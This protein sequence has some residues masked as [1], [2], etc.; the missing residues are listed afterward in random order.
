MADLKSVVLENLEPPM[1]EK[2]TLTISIAQVKETTIISLIND[3]NVEIRDGLIGPPSII[4][5][6]DAVDAIEKGV[7]GTNYVISNMFDDLLFFVHHFKTKP[8]LG[9]SMFC[10]RPRELSKGQ[11]LAKVFIATT[12]DTSSN[13]MQIEE[14]DATI[15]VNS[16]LIVPAETASPVIQENIET[17]QVVSAESEPTVKKVKLDSPTIENKSV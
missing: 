11:E 15:N 12:L 1:E 3:A 7:F 10:L 5:S 17:L 9:F 6:N 8:K 4:L 14:K 2:I 13:T 16:E